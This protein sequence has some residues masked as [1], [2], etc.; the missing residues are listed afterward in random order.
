MGLLSGDSQTL[1]VQTSL[2]V[3]ITVTAAKKWA[4]AVKRIM[5]GR[6]ASFSWGGYPA[7]YDLPFRG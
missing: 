3:N 5:K 2:V 1:G 6:L 7:M 4:P